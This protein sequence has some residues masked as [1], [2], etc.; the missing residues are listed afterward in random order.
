MTACA[1]AKAL[2]PFA[3]RSVVLTQAEHIELKH[4]ASYW[5][6]Q[7]GRLQQKC[8][9]L[10][11]ELDTSEAM[12]RDLKQRLYGKKSEKKTCQRDS[13]PVTGTTDSKSDGTPGTSRSRGQQRGSQGHGRTPRPNL[14]VI[15]ETHDVAASDKQCPCCGKA[16]Q[17]LA[18]SE[19]SEIIEIEVKGYKRQIKRKKY[20][21]R[22]Q[23][24]EVPGLI[25]APVAPRL[26]PK[27]GIGVSV[28]AEV[29]LSKFLF[30]RATHNL[31][32]D[33]A[34]RGLPLAPGTLTGGLKKIVPLLLPLLALLREKQLT[35]A[36][37]HSDETGWKVYEVL[38]G[39]VGYRWWLWVMQSNSVVYYLLV[40]SRSGDVPIEHFAGLDKHLDQVIVV[41][42]RY[43][44]Y[45]RLARENPVILLAFCWAHVRRDF[46]DAARS[47]P[48][49]KDWMLDWVEHIGTLYHLNKQ[50]LAVWDESCPLEEQAPEFHTCQQVLEQAVQQ[51]AE[52][53]DQ[54]LT[55]PELHAVQRDVLN[56]LANH[57]PG[58]TVFVKHPVVP[59]DNN[60]A[61]RRMR[62]PSM[63]RKN[64]YGSGSQWSAELAA[65]LFSL[66]QTI[67]LWG[68][69]PHHW[70]Y[71]YLQTCA[72]RGGQVPENLDPFIP[73]AMEEQRREAL[74]KPLPSLATGPPE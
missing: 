40:P 44:A 67:L 12:V 73:W 28:W 18:A 17:A 3:Q 66:F 47:W 71:D 61:E 11:Q 30:A 22:C 13:I 33:Y 43:K 50:R 70:L 72:N 59:M 49:L 27:S 38:E 32:T 24:T 19:D 37:F 16:Y 53:R 41:C 42:D 51:M 14:P 74:K 57:W 36:L 7:H 1:E 25:T 6:S 8:A 58:L 65:T 26:I 15:P 21:Q 31:C 46:L 68:L 9:G 5:K 56:S 54:L 45:Q 60:T 20:V 35:E 10:Q 69:N 34:L 63:G 62:N 52:Q 55:T 29:L 2:P 48:A 4:Q 23:C 64:Y 39:K